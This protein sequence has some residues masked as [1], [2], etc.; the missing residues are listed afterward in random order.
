M[1]VELVDI[2]CA[3]RSGSNV[4]LSGA[5]SASRTA[6]ARFIHEQSSQAN[7][8]MIVLGSSWMGQPPNGSTLF[9]EEMTAL[10][11]PAQD[12]L[13]RLLSRRPF[14]DEIREIRIISGTR[15]NDVE[16]MSWPFN[17][18]LFYRLNIIHIALGNQM[19]L[20]DA[21]RRATLTPIMVH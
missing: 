13:M 8:P 12:E 4:L 3:I 9:I 15:Y 19:P 20:N 6:M 11:G 16:L 5:D 2:E 1:Q 17:P 7:G 10:D 14:D 21:Y 18:D